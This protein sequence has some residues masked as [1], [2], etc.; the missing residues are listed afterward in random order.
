MGRIDDQVKLR[1][2]RIELG[3]IEAVLKQNAGLRDAVVIVRED[4]PG[5]K[6]IV[7]YFVAARE[8][9][10]SSSELRTFL[11][12]K[13]PEYMVPSMYVSL[14]E[15]PLTPNGKVNRRALSAPGEGRPELEGLYVAPRTELEVEVAGIW[16]EVLK[17]ERV[18]VDDNFFELG[19]HSLL[20]TQVVSRLRDALQVELPLR[21][22]F[23][24]PTVAALALAVTRRQGEPRD[25]AIS[26]IKR[27]DRGN[28]EQV[29]ASLDQLSDQ[30]VNALL[31][32]MLADKELKG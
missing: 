25:N 4:E 12:E 29:L 32:N 15:I 31:S 5:D 22:L 30:E 20:A 1:G 3:E 26:S 14:D 7:A 19:G 28:A 13:L 10:P 9:V 17:V 18:G 11:K 21:T 16:S 27:T 2:F 23:Q 24:Q 6:R 8:Q